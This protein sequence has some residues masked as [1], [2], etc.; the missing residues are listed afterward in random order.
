MRKI[1]SL[2]ILAI[3]ATA[4]A[5]PKETPAST[6]QPASATVAPDRLA[7]PMDQGRFFN[8]S[9]NCAICH[10]RLRDEAKTDVAIDSVWRAT[11]LGNAARD[12]YWL[13]TVRS[14][15]NL[16]PELSETIQKKCATCHMPMAEFTAVAEGEQPLILDAGF[17]SAGHPLAGLANDGVSCTLCHQIEGGNFGEKAGF[18]GGYMVDAETPQGSRAALGPFP[19]GKNFAAVMQSA[20]GFIPVQNAQIESAGLCGTCH[21]LYTPY[22]DENDQ[23]AG[24]FPEQMIYSE[25]ANSGYRDGNCQTC[26]MPLAKGGVQLSNTGGPKRSPF[27]QHIF[28]GGNAYMSRIFQHNGEAL[29]AAATPEQFETIVGHAQDQIENQSAALTI[30]GATV[31]NGRLAAEIQIQSKVGH[32]FPAG[33]PSRR[34]WLHITLLDKDRQVVFESGAFTADGKISANNN[35]LD[36]VQYEPHY[37]KITSADQVQIYEAVMLDTTGAVTTTLLRGASYG[38]DNRILPAGFDLEQAGADI[39]P[40]GTDGDPDFSAGSDTIAIDVLLGTASGP[41]TL[42]VELLYQTIGYRWA[43][44][45]TAQDTAEARLFADV[46]ASVSNVPLVAASAATEIV[47]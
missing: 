32:K 4:C 13:A 35:D 1:T 26:H 20:S 9:G 23:I 27:F 12:P 28:V 31:K 36:S 11:M 15:I 34:A 22:L 45:I 40:Y 17:R 6:A 30:S 18:S 2:L 44:N 5:A 29:G 3:L 21:N 47:P 38:K 25:W 42:S 10:S 43:A 8:G 19:A 33:F 24:E 7:L 14:E 46:S 16:A 41:Y 37:A 39:T